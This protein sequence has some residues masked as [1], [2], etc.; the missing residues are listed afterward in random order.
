MRFTIGTYFR[1]SLFVVM[2]VWIGC[3]QSWYERKYHDRLERLTDSVNDLQLDVGDWKR[4]ST[5]LL[6]KRLLEAAEVQRLE[7]RVE[8]LEIEAQQQAAGDDSLRSWRRRTT[9]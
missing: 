8:L 4:Y 2:F 3:Q 6:G 7:R 5:Y 1:W 9:Q